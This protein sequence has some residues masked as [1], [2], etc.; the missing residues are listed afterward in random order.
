VKTYIKNPDAYF[1]YDP[2]VLAR[3][4]LEELRETSGTG[5]GKLPKRKQTPKDLRAGK[6]ARH[7][8]Q[9]QNQSQKNPEPRKP[10]PT[11]KKCSKPN[12]PELANLKIRTGTNSDPESSAL[13]NPAEVTKNARKFDERVTDNR[14]RL[15]KSF[16]TRWQ[17]PVG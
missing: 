10:Q 15:H 2:T 16:D 5:N 9:N 6:Q 3:L 1:V 7:Q 14:T 12:Y 17:L 8:N 4:K 13:F 11:F